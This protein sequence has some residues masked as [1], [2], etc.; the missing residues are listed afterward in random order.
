MIRSSPSSRRTSSIGRP[1][2]YGLTRRERGAR[3]ALGKTRSAAHGERCYQ[4]RG[5]GPAGYAQ[6]VPETPTYGLFVLNLVLLPGERVPLHIFEPQLPPT[7]RRLRARGHPVRAPV[8]RGRG[9]AHRSAAPPASTKCSSATTTGGSAWSCAGSRPVEIVREANGHLYYSAQC[10]PCADDPVRVDP[11]ALDRRPRRASSRS[12]RRSPATPRRPRARPGCRWSYVLAAHVELPARD[13]AGA[14]GD[15]RRKRTPGPGHPRPRSRAGRGRARP[16]G[17]RPR[18]HQRQGPARLSDDRTPPAAPAAGTCAIGTC[19]LVWVEGPDAAS[20]LHG[21]VTCSVTDLPVGEGRLALLLDAKGHIGVQLQI[22]RDAE[23]GFTLIT[24]AGRRPRHSSRTSSD[25]ISRKTSRSLDPEQLAAADRRRARATRGAGVA[26][27]GV[28]SRHVDRG[29]PT[30]RPRSRRD[31]AARPS[32]PTRSSALRIRAGVARVGTD[33]APDDARAGGPASRTARSTSPRAATSARR[34]SRAPST[35]ARSP[36][37]ARAWSPMP[38]CRPAPRSGT[39]NARSGRSAS[40][41]VR[42]GARGHR[43]RHPAARGTRRR[44]GARRARGCPGDRA[45]PAA[46]DEPAPDARHARAGR[47]RRAR[48]G[49]AHHRRDLSGGRRALADVVELDRPGMELHLRRDT[50][51]RAAW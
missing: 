44:R 8:L 17:R 26:R 49:G 13:Q 41:A 51:R 28:D 21:L 15:A 46:C 40:V 35:A 34:R 50:P 29:R 10:R 27:A 16:P 36:R 45:T 1:G 9:H 33:T 24:D 48:L 18:A 25:S 30:T 12:P 20:F 32:A 7:V 47:R 23:T 14:A 11:G 22:V 39:P 38:R 5:P 42:S 19:G 31:S 6:T 43:A 2:S 37:A 4:R 3:D